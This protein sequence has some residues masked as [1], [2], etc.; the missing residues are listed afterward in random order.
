MFITV[1]LNPAHFEWH[2]LPYSRLYELST[3]IGLL[4]EKRCSIDF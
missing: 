2:W 4:D 1:A 3:L